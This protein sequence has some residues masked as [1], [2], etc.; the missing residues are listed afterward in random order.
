MGRNRLKE[1]LEKEGIAVFY[2]V[3]YSPVSKRTIKRILAQ[4]RTVSP[5]TQFRIVESI[6]RISGSTY[7]VEELF[8]ENMHRFKGESIGNEMVSESVIENDGVNNLAETA[9]Q[10]AAA[11]KD[12][13]KKGFPSS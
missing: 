1:T 7:S 13:A 8:T 3:Q 9:R 6:N 10:A 2:F 4:R 12:A 11:F 5:N